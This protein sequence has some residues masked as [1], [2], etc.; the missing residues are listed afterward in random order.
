MKEVKVGTGK[1]IDASEVLIAHRDHRP[2][3]REGHRI[4][5]SRH[6]LARDAPQS[7]I[8]SRIETQ[9]AIRTRGDKPTIGGK[10]GTVDRLVVFR[11]AAD[12]VERPREHAQA[13]LTQP[14]RNQGAVPRPGQLR[15]RG[16]ES[17]HGALRRQAAGGPVEQVERMAVGGKAG[18]AAQRRQLAVRRKRRRIERAQA[19]DADRRA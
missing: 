2:I 3:R 12:K 17:R 9:A 15:N 5:L 11:V 6:P 13:L 1:H 16:F 10:I 7:A 19:A 8:G 14:Y 4:R 18:V